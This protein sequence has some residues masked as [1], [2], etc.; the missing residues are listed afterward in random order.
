MIKIC[1]ICGKEFNAKQPNYII[2]SDSCRKIYH[3]E[4]VKIYNHKRYKPRTIYCK[5][6][7]KPIARY[8]L[9]SWRRY[10]EECVAQMAV[11]DLKNGLNST[12]SQNIKRALN[13]FFFTMNELKELA[14]E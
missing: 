5:I 7:G 6:C 2:C 14:N 13:L 1:K 8:D 4:T 12:N 9:H 10:H 11:E 3:R